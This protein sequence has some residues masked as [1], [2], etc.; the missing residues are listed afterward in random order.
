MALESNRIRV[1]ELDYDQIKLNLKNFLQGQSQFNSYD[2]EGSGLSVLLDILAYNTHYNS[3]YT[4][5]AVNEMFLDSAVKRNSVVSLAKMLGYTG[6]SSKG[7]IAVVDIVINNPTS[8]P[9]TLTLPKSSAFTTSVN[10]FTYTFYTTE[11]IS[12]STSNSTYAFPSVLLKEG[13]PL[14]YSYTAAS[15]VRYIIPNAGVDLSTLSI[16]VQNSGT[17][18]FTTFV[19]AGSI[20]DVGPTDN[21]YFVKEIDNGLYEITF[22]DDVIG[23]AVT[24]GNVVR[25]DYFTTNADAANGANIFRYNGTSLIGGTV[26]TTTITKAFGGSVPET[27][28]SIKYNAPK[29]YAAQNRAVTPDDYRTTVLNTFSEASSVA[30]WGGEDNKPPVYGK[31]YVCIKPKDTLVLTAQQKMDIRSALVKKSVVSI[32][33][34][35]VDPEYLDL[36]LNVTFY[37]NERLTKRTPV[38]LQTLVLNTIKAYNVTDLQKFDGV[39]RQSK[40]TRLIDMC[41]PS[42]VNSNINI[43]VHR[44]ILPRYDVN[45]E[46]TVNLIN[47]IYS[48]KVPEEA[49]QSSGFY[50]AGLSDVHYLQDDGLGNIMLYYIDVL[51]VKQ[52]VNPQIGTV[53]YATGTVSIKNLNIQSLEND[54]FELLFKLQGNDVVSAL[55]QIVQISEPHL[56]VNPISDKTVNGNLG[57]GNSFIFTS[58]RN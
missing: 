20:V 39:F 22:G 31:V 52:V 23:A 5:L 42:I 46:Y 58:S 45:A 44:Q 1:G 54:T 36:E 55:T 11:D 6:Y 50:V 21:V 18:T 8:F 16:T 14:S 48:A 13:I 56:S 41:E 7:A 43:I 19:E 29:S 24:N 57:A 47:P 15:S 12:I 32:I 4:N 27:V 33:P 49:V 3:L 28:D 25:I 34:E 30:V 26:A 37:Y 40:L 53:D 10:G 17:S 38:E 9:T 51:T 35:L 2:F